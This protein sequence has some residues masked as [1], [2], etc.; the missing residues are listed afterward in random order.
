M[1]IDRGIRARQ[2]HFLWG[3]SVETPQTQ[4]L[5]L[6]VAQEAQL[7]IGNEKGHETCGRYIE[8]YFWPL[9]IL[10]SAKMVP[11]PIMVRPS[12]ERIEN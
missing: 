11:E 1:H 2:R 3:S 4:S 12:I 5:T 10:V 6:A 7:F 8:E 9:K